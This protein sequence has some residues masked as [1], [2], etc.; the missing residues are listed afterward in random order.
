MSRAWLWT[1]GL[2]WALAAGCGRPAPGGGRDAGATP[3]LSRCVVGWWLGSAQ[4]CD[5]PSQ[6]ECAQGDCQGF[7]VYGFGA[8]G[9][10]YQ[11]LVSVSP[12]AHTLSSEGAGTNAVTLAVTCDTTHLQVGYESFAPAPSAEAEALATATAGGQTSFTS[13]RF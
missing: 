7:A 2:A 5:C 12:S 3:P 9:M 8:D 10:A 1:L 4:G 6:P 11:G 13:Q